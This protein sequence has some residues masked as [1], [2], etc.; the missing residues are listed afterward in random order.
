[1]MKS[2][3]VTRK[4]NSQRHNTSVRIM[5]PFPLTGRKILLGISG[6]I[7]AYKAV[8]LTRL[9]TRQGAEVRVI[10]TPSATAFVAPIT[11]ST[12]SRHPVQYE[13]MGEGE[14]N[15]HVELGLWAD[16]F[17]IAPAT[18]NTLSG[19]AQGRCDN[20]LLAA[21][22]SARCPVMIAPAMDLDMWEH[23]ST[24][25][26]VHQLLGD[27]VKLIPVG[28]GEL[29]SGL[30]G[31]GR[32][33][34][35]EVILDHIQQFLQADQ[36]LAGYTILITAGPTQEALDPV[37]FIS[38]HSS[39]K[40]GISLAEELASRGAS[41]HLVLGPSRLAPS[42]PGVQVIHVISALEMLQASEAIFPH[43]QAA[44]F[45]AAV[46]DYRPEQMEPDKIKKSGDHIELQLVK[47]PDIAATLG[48][49]KQPGQ[50]LVGFA[51]ETRDEEKHALQKLESKNLDF[52]VLNSLRDPGAGFETDTN[53]VTLYF[54][55][56]KSR[57]LGLKAKTAVA[58]DIADELARL[59]IPK[60]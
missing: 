45:A 52:I 29:A 32:M 53:K 23:P 27:E 25:R 5:A 15:N 28:H 60:D 1:M 50:I 18:A 24:Q 40:M 17:I 7:A 22:L 47:N 4:K 56:T 19:M 54:R 21:Y 44:I 8:F 41:V 26:N 46:A 3:I 39:G 36:T 48:R 51:L 49:R 37:R 59:L 12:L 30:S 58:G 14:W 35:P 34:E 10:M 9:L 2:I 38:N 43:C 31:P 13:I 55:D 33:A 57:A 20:L 42:H 6:S 11:F 16:L